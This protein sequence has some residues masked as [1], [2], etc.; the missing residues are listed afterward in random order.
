MYFQR[1][2]RRMGGGGHGI[3]IAACPCCKDNCKANLGA[4]RNDTGDA[5][6][7]EKVLSTVSHQTGV[8]NLSQNNSNRG[9]QKWKEIS[10]NNQNQITKICFFLSIDFERWYFSPPQDFVQMLDSL[11][12]WPALDQDHRGRPGE[13]VSLNSTY[14]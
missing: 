3:I 9:N 11:Q 5:L 1:K 2:G 8:P 4:H 10:K 13:M 7:C 6:L 12:V 14:K